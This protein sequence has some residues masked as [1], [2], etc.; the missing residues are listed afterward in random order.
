MQI[1]FFLFFITLLLS[2][3]SYSNVNL[4]GTLNVTNI[5]NQASATSSGFS[6]G[7]AGGSPSLGVPTHSNNDTNSITHSVVKGVSFTNADGKVDTSGIRNT[8]DGANETLKD[9]AK[10][11]ING[12]QVLV[13]TVVA[14]E[15]QQYGA[16]K[17]GDAYQNGTLNPTTHK[18]VHAILGCVS[19]A[20]M[21]SECGS[22]ALGAVSG[23]IAAELYYNANKDSSNR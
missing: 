13:S 12:L 15:I 21:G 16:G 8:L 14:T 20:V 19:G 2:G 22:G 1:R 11:N 6:G 3:L 9:P 17:I 7:F 18:V 23:E 5:Q 4:G 10:Q